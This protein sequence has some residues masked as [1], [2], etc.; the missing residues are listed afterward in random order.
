MLAEQSRVVGSRFLLSLNLRDL[1]LYYRQ[2]P[3]DTFQLPFPGAVVGFG[4]QVVTFS[5]HRYFPYSRELSEVG[6][7]ALGQGAKVARSL[8]LVVGQLDVEVVFQAGQ[9]L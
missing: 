4:R 6:L 2:L 5:G 1:P 8:H 3:P 9:Q 7:D